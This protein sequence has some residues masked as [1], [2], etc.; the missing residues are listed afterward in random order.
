[1]KKPEELV[2]ASN[3]NAKKETLSSSELINE[4]PS[5]LEKQIKAIQLILRNEKDRAKKINLYLRLSYLHVSIAKKYGVKRVKGEK[6]SVVEAKHLDEAEKILSFLLKNV[7]NNKRMLSTLYNIRGLVTYELD[8]PEKTVDNFLKSIELNSKNSQAEVMS[9]F[10]GEYYFESEKYDEAIKYYQ[11]FYPRM[12]KTQKALSDYKIAWSYLNKKEIDKAEHQFIKIIKEQLD[13]G[14][15]D[16]SFKDLAFILTQNKD[17][18][19]LINKVN[20]FLSDPAL[21][22]RLYY[23]CLLFFLQNS[24][25]EPKDLVFKEVLTIQKDPLEVL[26]IL[27]LKVSFEK[28]DIPSPNMVNAVLNLD[29][30]LSLVKKEIKAQFFKNETFQLEDDS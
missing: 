8:Q 19:V 26:K 6:V 30:R 28:R 14:I 10:I 29:K 5:K 11:M 22:G 23:Y 1:M 20:G 25:G 4:D 2:K 13:R 24:K 3:P 12:N 27:S 21:K 7:E 15:A 9:I 17:E 16:D 18:A